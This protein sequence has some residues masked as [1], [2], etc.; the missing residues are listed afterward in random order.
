MCSGN[1]FAH[2]DCDKVLVR[3]Y[4]DKSDTGTGGWST[5]NYWTGTTYNNS[6]AYV[7]S[8]SYRVSSGKYYRATGAHTVT[9]N[10][11]VEATDTSSDALKF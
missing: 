4:L 9:E 2:R 3:V 8:G 1:T 7:S 10:G 6:S 5:L 11:V